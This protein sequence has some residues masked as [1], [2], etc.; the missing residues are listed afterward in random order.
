M[1]VKIIAV[2]DINHCVYNPEGIDI[3]KLCKHFNLTGDFD[4]FTGAKLLPREE[5]ISI[6]TDI[7]IPAAMEGVI[8]KENAEQLQCKILCE[9]AN[10]PT[11][12]EAD[13]ILLN[14][15]VCIVP[16]IL[17]NSGGVIVSYFEWSQNLYGHYWDLQMILKEQESM[18]LNAFDNIMNMMQQKNIQSMRTAAFLVAIDRL[19]KAMKF[20]GWY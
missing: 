16:D 11:T 3:D 14:K 13:E 18:M 6:P 19:V 2:N 4:G 8:T 10:G 9:G 15:G 1:G 17:A 5:I 20:R 7:F 12:P